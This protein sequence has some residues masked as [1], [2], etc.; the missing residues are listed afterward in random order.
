MSVPVAIDNF[1]SH[2]G[3]IMEGNDSKRKE[4]HL[5]LRLTMVS[6]GLLSAT[7]NTS[8]YAQSGLAEAYCQSHLPIVSQAIQFRRDGI[9]IDVARGVADSAFDVN[10]DLWNWLNYAIEEAYKQPDRLQEAIQNGNALSHCVE[11]VRGY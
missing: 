10:V 8:A 6:A 9:P 5:F 3:I 2:R 1:Y 4:A 7:I 11:N